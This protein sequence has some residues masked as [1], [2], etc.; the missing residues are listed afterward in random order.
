MN[1]LFA[2]LLTAL[3]TGAADL[4]V[5]LAGPEWPAYKGNAGIT[6]LSTDVTI[7]P[8]FKLA[9]SYRL[10]GDGSNDA[11]GGVIVAG[12]KVFVSVYNTHS[13]L[14]LDARTGRL[15]WEY[16]G[17]RNTNRSIPTYADGRLF[18]WVRE[19]PVSKPR[20]AAL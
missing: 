6:G 3:L 19:T 11:G 5:P 8:P 2:S 15:L 17:A 7:K 16:Q 13:I 18:V 4:D 9:W 1:P 12:G 10:D 14:A 20:S